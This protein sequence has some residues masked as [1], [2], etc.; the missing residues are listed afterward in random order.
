MSIT[1]YAWDE[2]SGDYHDNEVDDNG[3]IEES[4]RAYIKKVDAEINVQSAYE[5]KTYPVAE[6]LLT[7]ATGTFGSDKQFRVYHH[8]DKTVAAAVAR[9]DMS[10]YL[11]YEE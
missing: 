1:V 3:S 11:M 7:V 5:I 4:I 2:V 9:M 8:P 6:G 10:H